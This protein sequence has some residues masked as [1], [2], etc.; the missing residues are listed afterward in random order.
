MTASPEETETTIPGGRVE[1]ASPRVETTSPRV[2]TAPSRGETASPRVETT[3]P[4]VKT[5]SPRVKTA[6]PR[7][8]TASPR[9]ETAP[10][11]E[12]AMTVSLVKTAAMAPREGITETS[13]IAAV[14]TT[15]LPVYLTREIWILFLVFELQ[16][17]TRRHLLMSIFTELCTYTLESYVY[18]MP[19]TSTLEERKR[20]NSN[21]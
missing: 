15:S 21:G 18:N 7:A 17:P 6:P 4:R 8:E 5:A 2:E 13:L 1:T 16:V 14:V 12:I 20:V 3:S 11:G 9:V 19:E 10:R